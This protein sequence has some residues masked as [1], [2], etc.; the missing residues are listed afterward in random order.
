LHSSLTFV[1]DLPIEAIAN[2][3]RQG[4]PNC[5][6]E[7][8]QPG[9]NGRYAEDRRA[10]H[11]HCPVAYAPLM[12]LLAQ[13]G[14]SRGETLALRWSDV[15]LTKAFCGSVARFQGPM[16]TWFISEPKTERSPRN[17]PLSPATVALLGG[18]RRAKQSSGSRRPRSWLR[19]ASSSPRG[20]GQQSTLGGTAGDQRQPRLWE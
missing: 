3:R 20:A 1:S 7:T 4:W 9:S 14:R 10:L 5:S 6:P 2:L 8:R 13:A 15:D 11:L 12:R 19:R 18:S 17:V 16:G